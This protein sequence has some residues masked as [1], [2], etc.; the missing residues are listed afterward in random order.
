M[1]EMQNLFLDEKV[2][3]A[4]KLLKEYEP[5]EGYFVAFSGG[6]DSIVLNGGCLV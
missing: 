5:P 3:R 1:R 6:K 4:I 2:E